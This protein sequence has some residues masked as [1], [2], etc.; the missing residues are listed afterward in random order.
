MTLFLF[1]LTL[2]WGF[3]ALLY[4]LLLRH[5][6]F[7]RANRIYL[8][9]TA[10]LGILLAAWPAEQLPVPTD[11]TGVPV[12]ELPTFTVGLQQVEVISSQWERAEYL[13]LIYW[14]GFALA[15]AR[16]LWGI[17]VIVRMAHRGHTEQLPEGGVLI[18]TAE[19]QVPF[20]FFQWVFVPLGLEEDA[21]ESNALMLAHERAHA[22]GWHSADVLFMELLSAVFWFHPLAH[23]FR[24]SLRTVHEYL[25]DAEASR[26]SDRKQYGLLLIGQSQ[27]GMPIAFANHFFQ[28]PLKQ[29]LVMLTKKTSAPIRAIKFG[30]VAPAALLFAMLFR[31]AP[32]IAQVVDE[33]HQK[34]VRDLEQ[35][36]WVTVDTVITFDPE[37]YKQDMKF[38]SRNLA[39]VLDESG[40]LL[41]QYSEQPPQFPGGQEAFIQ[42][43]TKN[44]QYPEAAAKEGSEGTIEVRFI[45]DDD[46]EIEK[47]NAFIWQS[48]TRAD[49]VAE[50]ERVVRAMPRWIPAQHKGEKVRC[51]MRLPIKFSLSGQGKTGG[52]ANADPEFPGG[53]EAMMKYL[54]EN[55]R[56]PEAARIAKAEGGAVI[57]FIVNEDGSLAEVKPGLN[58]PSIH[59][60]LI[61][62]A[63]RVVKAMPKWK[64]A[65]KDGQVLKATLCIPV[66]FK[67]V[68]PATAELFE[69]DVQPEYPGGLQ[70]MYKFLGAQIKYPE[71]AKN[72]KAEGLVVIT[73]VV[74]TDGSLGSFESVKT[75]RQDFSDEVIRV[76]K[77]SPKWKPGQKDGKAVKVKYTL[78]FKFQL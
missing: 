25:A 64:P 46:G 44:L 32:A 1:K 47:V 29:R 31:Q 55:L 59:P 77:L 74:E 6:T 42:F 41:Y 35:S 63:I 27:S 66:K 43:L 37:T 18:R 11:D 13:W 33:K 61:T 16:V 51:S 48:E 2:C 58:D 39:P 34:F 24:K 72:E 21:V 73:F 19:A 22:R 30:L 4:A 17:Y 45:V 9:S 76:L 69:V 78:P 57:S 8:L 15:L 12:I 50:A 28:S 71:A 65:I 75:V 20:S 38:V 14:V 54:T 40:K 68:G 10:A 70:E 49:L 60:D 36:G 53:M 52:P 23:W 62:E 26:L 7:F 67:L 3:F 56:Y 5:E